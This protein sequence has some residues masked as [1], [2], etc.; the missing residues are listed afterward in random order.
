MNHYELDRSK[1][2]LTIRGQV[3]TP[4]EV[5]QGRWKQLPG[6]TDFDRELFRFLKE[7]WSDS[8][9]L[10]VKTSGSTGTPKQMEVEKSR[11]MA[12]ARLTCQFLGL[13]SGDSAL[14]CMSLDY[15]AGKM[16]VVRSLVAGLNLFLIEPT[17]HPLKELPVSIDFAAM[18]PLQVVNSLAVPEEAQRFERICQVIIGGS[19]IDA[20][21]E[22][23]LRELSND[24]YSSYGM[25]ETLSHIALRRISGESASS[26]YMPFE[27]VTI[28][29][30]PEE[31]L[32]IDAPLVSP[33]PLVTNDLAEIHTDGSFCILGRRDHVI[34]S[35][36]LKIQ[37]EE[38]ER[39]L[40]PV[41]TGD[42]A[43]TAMPDE[44]FGE[45]LVL[46]V[47]SPMDEA[48]I[49]HVLPPYYLPKKIVCI[50]QLPLLEN[51]KIDRLALKRI[52][53]S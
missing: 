5:L 35:G 6:L 14:L 28:S 24:I 8:P 53:Q 26:S 11:M 52:A 12:S 19:S 36:G 23:R 7:W 45:A 51:T 30:S 16:M 47:T 43:V 34:I 37:I 1:Q 21:L 42:Y 9:V 38:V 33:V 17:G 2:T 13:K 29:L 40:R 10:T 48:S 27:Q 50:E 20:Q 3:F 22:N 32:I 4:E 15:I 18:V 41:I 46:I 31:T 49:A 44:K 39:L 25:T